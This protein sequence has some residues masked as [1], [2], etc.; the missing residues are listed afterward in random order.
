MPDTL[1]LFGRTLRAETAHAGLLGWLRNYWVLPGGEE[2]SSPFVIT[3]TERDPADVATLVDEA[4][5]WPHRTSPT[6]VPDYTIDL[7]QQG[8]RWLVGGPTSGIAFE[9]GSDKTTTDEATIDEATITVWGLGERFD[10]YTLFLAVGEALRVSGLVSL[11]AAAAATPGGGVTA[12]LGP[13]GRGKTTTLLRSVAAGWAPV[14][15]D[16][17]WLEPATLRVFGGERGVR[18]LP[19]V[20]ASLPPALAE[21]DWGPPTTDKYLLPYDVLETHYGAARQSGARLRQVAVLERDPETPTSAWLALSKREAAI[22]LWQAS[23]LPITP[24][25]RTILA[26]T[27]PKIVRDTDVRRLRLGRDDVRDFLAA[28][29]SEPQT[30]P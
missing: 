28:A 26:A 3:I 22:A 5:Q 19:E 12:F 9:T 14:S 23:G 7:Y 20:L 8:G 25:A 13:S 11:H 21:R 6:T 18:V 29:L 15:E 27:I 16:M 2:G 30:T 4:Q 17:L 1:D 10:H 24:Q